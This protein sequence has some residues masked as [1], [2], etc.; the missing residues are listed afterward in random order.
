VHPSAG[1]LIV[2][3]PGHS[4]LGQQRLKPPLQ[5]VRQLDCRNSGQGRCDFA[6]QVADFAVSDIG[7][8][9]NVDTTPPSFPFD[10][11]PIVGE[12]VAFYYNIPGLT[13]QL[14]LT[15]D[16]AYAIFTGGITNW[17]APALAAANPGVT[18]PNLAISPVTE[19]DASV[20]NYAMEQWCI[21][22][23][24]ALW[25]AFVNSQEAQ[26]GGPTD[27]VALSPTAPNP[28]W[29]GIQGGLDDA[30]TTPVAAD[31]ANNA[32]AVGAVQPQYA[33]NQGLTGPAKNVALVEN[34]SGDFTAPTPIDVASALAYA[35]RRTMARR[36]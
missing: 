14:Q 18:L 1:R 5:A 19:D 11:V 26:F 32:G 12:G 28:N 22:E 10:Y 27:G 33:Q 3:C 29:P 13:K 6:D 35:T 16:T 8:I 34:A 7:Y 25:A 21:A 2:C 9:G 30:S 15:S 31:V 4:N 24:P 17:D 23:Q 20:T 36:T